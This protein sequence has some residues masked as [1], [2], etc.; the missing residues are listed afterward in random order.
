[1]SVHFLLYDFFFNGIFLLSYYGL[2]IVGDKYRALIILYYTY[3]CTYLL[4]LLVYS[5]YFRHQCML[6]A[7]LSKQTIG[8]QDD[9]LHFAHIR[10]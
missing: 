7:G 3:V 1:M 9:E 10:I 2:L 8:L 6:V 4:L 5:Y